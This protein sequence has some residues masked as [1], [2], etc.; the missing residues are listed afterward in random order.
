MPAAFRS[1]ITAAGLLAFAVLAAGCETTIDPFPEHDRVFSVFGYLDA[2]ADT[3]FIRITPLRRQLE[4]DPDPLDATVTLEHLA[5][6][7]SVVLR[8]SLFLIQGRPAHNFWAA[9]TVAPE[10]TYRLTVR[11]ADGRT[12]VATVTL[13]PDFPEPVVRWDRFNPLHYVSIPGVEHL[14]GAVL[15]YD[16]VDPRSGTRWTF[17]FDY[18]REAS[19]FSGGYGFTFYPN[20]HLD[21]ISR[22]LGG[23]QI[24]L[25]A[26]YLTATAAGPDWPELERIDLEELALPHVLANVENGVGFV[27]GVVSRT[28]RWR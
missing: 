2:A 8:D 16:V 3:H 14:V 28:S 13:P 7:Q 20:E 21:D 19:P 27:G 18:T 9:F 1:R 26:A 22:R 24:Q 15:R 4:G 25:E 5:S 17:T 23:V 10:E 6:G 11:A 12:S